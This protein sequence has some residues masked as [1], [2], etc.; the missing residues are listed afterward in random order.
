M[1][2]FLVITL[3]SG[4]TIYTFS[5]TYPTLPIDQQHP[6]KSWGFVYTK[7][8]VTRVV[9]N[10]V[11]LLQKFDVETIN[12]ES[13]SGAFKDVSQTYGVDYNND[14]LADIISVTYDGKLIIKENKG[15]DKDGKITFK[16][17]KTFDLTSVNFFAVGDGTFIVDDFDNDGKLDMFLYNSLKTGVYVDDVINVNK[18]KVKTSFIWVDFDFITY[19]T[20][21][22]MAVYDYNGDNY[23]DIIY[24]DRAGRVWVWLNNPTQGKNR[25]FYTTVK[26]LFEDIDIS[27]KNDPEGFSYS[28]GA[29]LD[30]ADLN[31][32]GIVDIVAGHTNKRG[33][34]IYFGK[35]VNGT[36]T[37][38]PSEKVAIVKIDGTLN[39]DI[40]TGDDPGSLPSFAPTIIKIADI[41]QD[42]LKDVFVATDAWRQDKDFGGT[43]YVFKGT[44]ITQD[45]IP[46]FES[47]ELVH[48]SYEWENN[49]PYDFD[50]G[51]LA[52]L[53]GNGMPD[54]IAADGNHSGSFYM[55]KTETYNTYVLEN[56]VMVSAPLPELV[57]IPL[58]ELKDNF[59]KSFK[60]TFKVANKE[61]GTIRVRY[62]ETGI[63]DPQSLDPEDYPIL[64]EIQEVGVEKS[65]TI[66][67][68]KPRP[69]PQLIIELIPQDQNNSPHIEW[70]KIEVETASAQVSERSIYWYSG[71][72]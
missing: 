43:V 58:S 11:Y 26:L 66:Q 60:I 45:D 59:I 69:D 63:K 65:E 25:F 15:V 21:T 6:E 10:K 27:Y 29:V 71:G 61:G 56:G 17:K 2:L 51:T 72:D 44:E 53:D 4:K 31:N 47:I 70:Y 3:T 46:K 48:G 34:F 57:G 7:N 33:V 68:S 64:F 30:V 37:F 36:L 13:S 38:D 18:N 40:V 32:D 39:S 22:A 55:I 28:G 9:N 8:I 16:D 23:D 49:P 50:A 54:L 20:V 52:D 42:G 24:S 1:M 67:L 35:L 5:A 19:W 14:G 62:S 12:A 41:D